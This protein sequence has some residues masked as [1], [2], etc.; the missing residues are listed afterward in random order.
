MVRAVATVPPSGLAELLHRWSALRALVAD[1]RRCVTELADRTGLPYA[2]LEHL[3]RVRNLCAHPTANRWPSQQA[4]D[5]AL[6]TARSATA[7]LR[8]APPHRPGSTRPPAVA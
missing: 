5:R 2:D 7:R 8:S 6:G 4:V 3:R 1:G